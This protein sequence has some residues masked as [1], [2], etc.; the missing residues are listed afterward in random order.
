MAI[1]VALNV[2]WV[3]VSWQNGV[4]AVLGFIFFLLL[5]AGMVVYTVFMIREIRRNEQHD[6]FINAVTHELKTPVASIR[7]YLQTLQTRDLD[8][9]KRREFYQICSGQRPFAHTSS[10]CWTGST[11]RTSG[12]RTSR[13]DLRELAGRAY[14]L[15]GRGF[16]SEKAQFEMRCRSRRRSSV[17]R[18]VESR[19]WNLIDN[20]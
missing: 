13:V 2:G 11:Q 16:I 9:A 18:R 4:L 19:V 12:A 8:E 17:T 6:S 3:V 10:R 20:A 15:A 5:I 14:R 1:A 7:L